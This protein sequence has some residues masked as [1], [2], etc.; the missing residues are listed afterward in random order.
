MIPMKRCTMALLFSLLCSVVLFGVM[1]APSFSITGKGDAGSIYDFA[2]GA[3]G[4]K[5]IGGFAAMFLLALFAVLALLGAFLAK[6]SYDDGGQ[7]SE[8]VYK[9][10]A[11]LS[12]LL[13]LAD[14]ILIF[15]SK[16]VAAAFMASNSSISAS[17][18]KSVIDLSVGSIL[19][20]IIAL[21]ACVGCFTYAFIKEP[22]AR[23]NYSQP[24]YP[25]Q[26]QP[27][28]PSYDN[29]PYTNP[30]APMSEAPHEEKP[31]EPV[32]TETQDPAKQAALLK[33]YF[34]LMKAGAISQEEFNEK[35]KEIL[36]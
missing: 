30:L 33:T 17:S 11:V 35:K 7:V 26:S 5:Q 31:A 15:C 25:Q 21:L 32:S 12:A 14:G 28:A 16:D 24:T 23:P 2:F 22:Y 29:N 20:G 27:M 34:D 10:F 6:H 36:K 3:G 9:V 13:F 4:F 19:S 18:Y 1:A 8:N